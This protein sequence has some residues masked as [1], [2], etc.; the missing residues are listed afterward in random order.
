M[1]RVNLPVQVMSLW[2]GSKLNQ[3]I[4]LAP[5]LGHVASLQGHGTSRG[6]KR[7]PGGRPGP[8]LRNLGGGMR[9]C[10]VSS[11]VTGEQ[12]HRRQQAA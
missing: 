12:G 4:S 6:R 11:T 8:K 10:L 1:G 2:D 3:W 5:D 9:N 7:W